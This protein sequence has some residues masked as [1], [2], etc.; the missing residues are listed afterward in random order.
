[1][2]SPRALADATPADRDRYLDALR[3]VS[4]TVVV[5]GH[6]LLAAVW[7]QDGVLRSTSALEIQPGLAWITWVLQVMPVFFLVGG[8]VNARSWRGAVRDGIPYADWVRGRA[9][10]LLRPTLPVVWL[11]VVAGPTMVAAGLFPVEAARIGSQNALIPLWFLAVYL[12]VIALTPL[13]LALHSRAGPA[14]VVV[15]AL[16]VGGVDALERAGVPVGGANYLLVWTAAAQLGIWWDGGLLDR[17]AARLALGLAGAGGLAVLVGPLGYPVGMVGAAAASSNQAPP[18]LALL[19][20]GCLQVA[21]VTS[22]RR[23]VARWLERPAPWRAVVAVNLFA[24]TLFLWHLTVLSL[25][26]GL[27]VGLGAFPS[28][29]PGTARW[30]WTRPLWWGALA[31]ALVPVARIMARLE[32]AAARPRPWPRTAWATPAA[33]LVVAA[34]AGAIAVLVLA[35]VVATG[36]AALAAPLAAV[37]LT[38]TVAAVDGLRAARTEAPPGAALGA[39]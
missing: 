1:V 25:L 34:A 32:W 3:G 8:V 27:L 13:L 24:M 12:V 11:W 9:A 4:I 2:G 39:R 7:V 17:P 33:V 21:L 6:W 19:A 38:L 22:A 16:L 28:V 23:P 36:P 14:V 20:L 35:G 26:V 30:W 10:R 37:A 15:L 29:P 31:A 18:T 5:L